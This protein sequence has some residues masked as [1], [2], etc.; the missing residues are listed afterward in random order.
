MAVTPTDHLH[1][2][3]AHDHCVV[4]RFLSLDRPALCLF[5]CGAAVVVRWGRTGRDS[6]LLAPQ[7]IDGQRSGR[8][9]GWTTQSVGSI[10]NH[11]GLD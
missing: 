3:H 5:W 10:A 9:Y 7:G 1:D 8:V 6:W 4:Y 2:R 11:A